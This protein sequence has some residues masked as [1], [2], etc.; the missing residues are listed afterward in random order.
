MP[1]NYSYSQER[2]YRTP[3]PKGTPPAAPTAGKT[4]ATVRTP[5]LA[6]QSMAA[7]WADIDN[8]LGGTAAMRAAADTYIAQEPQEGT[9]A[10]NRRLNRATLAPIYKWL[11]R[12]F[13]AMILRKPI[14]VKNT[15]GL[16]EPDFRA[17]IGYH[18]GED[19]AGQAVVGHLEDID[20]EGSDLQ[21]FAFEW[22]CTAIHYG[23]AAVEVIYPSAEGIETRADEVTAGLRPHWSVYN[24]PAI[25]GDRRSGKALSRIRLLQTRT[26]PDGDWGEQLVEQVMVYRQDGEQV[27]WHTYR[28]IDDE[29][30]VSEEGALAMAEATVPVVYLHS[31]RK[32]RVAPP[33]M[34]EVA[35][36]NIRH[37]QVSADIDHNC[38]IAAVPRFFLFGTTPDELGDIGASDE[39]VCIPNPE[40]RAEW[41]SAKIDAFEPNNQRLE[42]LEVQMMRLGVGAMA[43]QKNVGESAAA[44]R[45][46]RTQGDSQLAILAQNLQAGLNQCLR[47]HCSY[48][49]VAPEN[50]PTVEVSRD[51]DLTQMDAAMIQALTGVANAGKLSTET[52][53]HLLQK[54]ELGLPEQWTP[55]AEQERIEAEFQKQT[56]MIQQANGV[57]E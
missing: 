21:Q 42:Q 17:I 39:A 8:I 28:Q 1:E 55:E 23:H 27:E 13:V 50:A 29:W 18:P 33:P 40:A 44:K 19:D 14:Q 46:D 7:A 25:L 20:E 10:Y 56:A 3:P 15:G 53:L 5:S 6:N 36:L 37:F 30:T 26:E 34:L 51:F 48:M 35:Y 49:G 31:D 41:N 2:L 47:L 38:H 12:A 16:T 45:L 22:L 52:F 24:G 11:V 9:D 57:L 4:E 32:G 43:T 54:G